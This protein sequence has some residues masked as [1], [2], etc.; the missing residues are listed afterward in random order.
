MQEGFNLGLPN[1]IAYVSCKDAGA[2]IPQ[3]SPVEI[4]RLTDFILGHVSRVQLQTTSKS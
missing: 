1:I 3:F 4:D 2:Q